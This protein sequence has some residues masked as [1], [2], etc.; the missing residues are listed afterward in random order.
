MLFLIYKIIDK[1]INLQVGNDKEF[2]KFDSKKEKKEE[3]NK[4]EHKKEEKNIHIILNLSEDFYLYDSKM[5]I[6]DGGERKLEVSKFK[7]D[8]ERIILNNWFYIVCTKIVDNKIEFDGTNK[9]QEIFKI[10]KKKVRVLDQINEE[11]ENEF[12]DFEKEIKEDKRTYRIVKLLSNTSEDIDINEENIIMKIWYLVLFYSEEKLKLITPS[13]CLPFE[14]ELL[15]GIKNIYKYMD[16]KDVNNIISFTKELA[17]LKYGSINFIYGSSNTFLYKI[18]AGFFN[19]SF[20]EYKYLNSY[21]T[22]INHEIKCYNQLFSSFNETWSDKKF[23]DYSPY[24]EFWSDKKNIEC[25]ERQCLKLKEGADD[26]AAQTEKYRDQ[27]KELISEV[28]N[29]NFE[30]K[31][32]FKQKLIKLLENKL[33]NPTEEDIK[34]CHSKINKFLQA[35]KRKQNKNQILLPKVGQ[36]HIIELDDNNPDIICLDILKTYSLNHKKITNIF[37]KSDDIITDIFQ[38]DKEIEIISDILGKHALENKNFILKHK[39]KV[40]GILRALILFKIIKKGKNKERIKSYFA[41]FLKL[42]NLI[43]EQ[44]GGRGKFNEYLVSWALTKIN[45]VDLEDYLIIPKFEPQDFI[46]LFL[47]EN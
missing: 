19:Y 27:L 17:T 1:K 32:E 26:S 2:I 11:Y 41:N 15:N 23:C 33:I 22:Q 5:V 3:E 8:E 20:I 47:I 10:V 9:I 28:K 24:D 18:Q 37:E 7:N 14:K 46:Y 12:N 30:E 16:I 34:T 4:E 39:N 42:S 45:L 36:N 35:L 29:Y 43:N 21:R 25:L 6:N 13:F 38:L 44:N 31:E 40:M